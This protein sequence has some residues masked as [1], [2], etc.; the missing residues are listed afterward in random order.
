M[1]ML[2][3]LLIAA[4]TCLAPAS[5]A[6]VDI[7]AGDSEER[8][9][10][11]FG[12]PEGIMKGGDTTYLSYEG[13]IVTI[14]QGKVVD[15]PPDFEHAAERRRDAE[16]QRRLAAE[17]R[18]RFEEEQR[19]KGLVL[20]EGKWLTPDDVRTIEKKQLLESQTQLIE[21]QQQQIDQLLKKRA[22]PSPVVV[23]PPQDVKNPKRRVNDPVPDQWYK[24][25][26]KP[27]SAAG[28]RLKEMQKRQEQFAR[29][30]ERRQKE[31]EREQRKQEQDLARQQREMEWR[32]RD[33]ERQQDDME[34]KLDRFE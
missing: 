28:R 10:S 21:K 6:Q 11:E 33:L 32:Q 3:P 24:L 1:K 25:G 30:A 18:A 16:K 19:A 27:P 17:Q 7:R 14:K 26:Y 8:V 22:Q 12:E 9:L 34:R 20:H 15:F 13:G 4:A 2:I 5:K 23:L 31:L 29:N